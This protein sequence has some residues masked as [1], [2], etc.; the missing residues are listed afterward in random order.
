[1]RS[2]SGADAACPCDGGHLWKTDEIH[3]AEYDESTQAGYRPE[4]AGTPVIAV[5]KDD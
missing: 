2:L 4:S 5:Y 1:M 3:F